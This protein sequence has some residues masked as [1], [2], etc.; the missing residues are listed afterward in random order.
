MSRCRR[1]SRD[2]GSRRQAG[3]TTEECPLR[4]NPIVSVKVLDGGETEATGAVQQY[5]NLPEENKWVSDGIE[6][7]DRLTNLIRAKVRFTREGAERFRIR[8]IPGDSNATYS[9]DEKGRN[10]D[11]DY[12]PQREQTVTTEADGTKVLEDQFSLAVAGGNSYTLEAE[13]DHGNTVQSDEIQVRRRVFL[14]EIKME[15]APCASSLS[16]FTGEFTNHHLQIIQL[17][18]VQMARIENLGA[19]STPFENAARNAYRS[20]QGKNKEP[21]CV[22]IGYT[23]HEA[24]KDANVTLN[25][26]NMRV[27]PGQGPLSLGIVNA[28]GNHGY[29]WNNIVT[30][31]GW[32]VSASFLE[33]GA[34]ES[35]RVNILEGK[36]T[37]VQA[38]GFPADMCDSVRVVVSDLTTTV[39][40]GTVR[41][42]VNVVNRMRGGLSFTDS[43]LICVCTRAWWSTVSEADQNQTMIHEMGHKIGMVPNN[44]DL[45]RLPN[46]YDDSGHVGSHCHAGVSAMANYS[47]A[48]GSTCVIFG[49]C[50]GRTA[51]CTDCAGA[52]KKQDVSSGWSAF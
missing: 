30:G 35:A 44:D 37:S 12:R 1:P 39:K 32:F 8:I 25:Y 36:C 47:G 17:P 7:I 4:Q 20:S 23:D 15:G 19:D 16:T 26:N 42:V 2:S 27:G 51:F 38:S 9:D 33:N 13:D 40:Q 3:S 34:A 21:Y 29:L 48:T 49:A 45:D 31:E 5:V 43:N 11:Y 41:L 52:V 6:N 28:A 10:N 24:V 22:A 46:Q 50:N 18:S 14:Q